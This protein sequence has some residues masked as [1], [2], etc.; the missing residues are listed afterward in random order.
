MEFFQTV[1]GKQ[2]F[3]HTFPGLLKEIKR[4]NNLK[5]KELSLKEKELALKEKEI[6]LKEK[7]LKLNQ[8]EK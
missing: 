5:E 3:E 6:E 8:R 2:F 4:S 7:E 1:M